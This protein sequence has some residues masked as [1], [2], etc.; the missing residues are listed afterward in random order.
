[1]HY[2]L[3]PINKY[4]NVYFRIIEEN[5]D[6]S[7]LRDFPGQ[8]FDRRRLGPRVVPDADTVLSCKSVMYTSIL[9]LL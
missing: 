6:V 8:R 5:T 3:K 7:D 2:L 4:F 1:M 9:A